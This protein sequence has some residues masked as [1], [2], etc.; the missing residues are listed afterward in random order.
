MKG[1]RSSCVG[2]VRALVLSYN[3]MALIKKPE[4]NAFIYCMPQMIPFQE[5]WIIETLSEIIIGHS[6][7]EG[8][9]TVLDRENYVTDYSKMRQNK[10]V[11]QNWTKLDK[12]G[13][14]WTK[15]GQNR[16]KL[17]KTGQNW[18]KLDKTAQNCTKL[19]KTAQNSTKTE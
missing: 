4:T 19:L 16:T 10:E 5:A 3:I 12:T 13:Q 18:T 15:L 8:S 7:K 14:N 2:K 6:Y 1:W 9:K 11:G 17:D